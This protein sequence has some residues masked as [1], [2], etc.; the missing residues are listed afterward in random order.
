[1]KRILALAL[2]ALMLCGALAEPALVTVT[3]TGTAAVDVD[4]VA[5]GL[6]VRETGADALETQRAANLK[7][8]AVIDAIEALNIQQITL[9]TEGIEIYA[10]YDYTQSPEQLAGYNATTR[11][12]IALGETDAAGAVIDAAFEAGANLLEY[13]QFQASDSSAAREEALRLAVADA[14]NKAQVIAEASGMTLSSVRTITET[15]PGIPTSGIAARAESKDF[16]DASTRLLPSAQTVTAAV[17]VV[18]EMI[19]AQ[20]ES[21][22]GPDR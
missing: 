13:V 4:S 15:D 12:A 20:D 5:V 17:T 3:G 11:L 22:D 6:G 8:N 1:M 9:Q 16:A 7:M 2:I 10:V 14:Q 21:N 18:Y 19:P